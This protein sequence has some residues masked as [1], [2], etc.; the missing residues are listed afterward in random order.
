M[1]S[2]IRKRHPNSLPVLM[3][4]ASAADGSKES[5]H[6]LTQRYLEDKVKKLEAELADKDEEMQRSLRALEQK[7]NVMKVKFSSYKINISHFVRV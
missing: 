2:I 3:W 5:E 6:S 7:Y 1:E 4:A